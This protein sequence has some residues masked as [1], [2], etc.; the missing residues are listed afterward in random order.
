MLPV[1]HFQQILGPVHL[2]LPLYPLWK[3]QN[4]SPLLLG[5]LYQ[6][7]HEWM[8][9]PV[10]VISLLLTIFP[11]VP[12]RLTFLDKVFPLVVST[13]TLCNCN[14]YLLKKT[15]DLPIE[16]H[17]SLLLQ[18]S[19]FLHYA[20]NPGIL[21]PYSITRENCYTHSHACFSFSQMKDLYQVS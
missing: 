3:I 11:F 20:F 21:C 13:G 5:L 15:L 1:K 14:L 4:F 10:T 7:S 6:S 9:P 18:F 12:K 2:Q 8:T 19:F 16:S 17:R